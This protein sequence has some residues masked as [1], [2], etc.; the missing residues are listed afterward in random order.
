[1]QTKNYKAGIRYR[2]GGRV[3]LLS[4]YDVWVSNDVAISVKVGICPGGL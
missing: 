1:V 4:E 3:E 2:N